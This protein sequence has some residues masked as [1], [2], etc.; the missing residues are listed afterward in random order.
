MPA[1]LH[2]ELERRPFAE[3]F[4]ISGYVFEATDLLLVTLSNGEHRGRGEAAG[5]YYLG[6]DADNMIAILEEHRD[7]IEACASREE[8]RSLLPAGGAR[9]AVDCAM[10]EL[11]AARSG[12][13]AWQLAGLSDVKPVTTTFTV[14]A[15]EPA[16]MA[17]TARKYAGA[18]AI[19]VKLTGELDLDVARVAAIRGARPDVWLGVDANQG[20]AVADLERL[21][22]ALVEQRVSL[23]EQ[24]LARG[25]E[26]D[27]T[28]YDGPIPLAADESA[29][30]LED[31][32]GLVGRFQVLNIKLDKC[33]GLTE[34]LLMA[35]EARRLGLG[36]MVGN[37]TGTSL[38]MA[39]AFIV[40]QQCDF[41]D[42]DGPV[43][44]AEDRHPSVVYENG[45]IWC[46]DDVW[47]CGAAVRQ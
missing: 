4:R 26:A 29:L 21:V 3:P 25:R 7:A 10:W 13:P 43:F 27:L 28:G 5:A 33:G 9:N 23:L 1:A 8:L 44:L 38:A 39:P 12:R 30:G 45:T 20:F 14:G 19:K 22:G 47:G 37:M 36:V 2:F 34:A 42:L 11:E 46:P 24:P 17:E 6:D 35:Q 32:A 16:A 31:V 41:V 40:G 15:D 18:K